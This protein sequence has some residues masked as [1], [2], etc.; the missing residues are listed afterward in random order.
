MQGKIITAVIFIHHN[1][2][3]TVKDQNTHKQKD[4][5]MSN[6]RCRAYCMDKLNMI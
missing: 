1:L 4:I 2:V 6:T 3:E 5:A